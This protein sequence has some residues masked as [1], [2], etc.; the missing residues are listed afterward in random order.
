MDVVVA[1]VARFQV[2]VEARCGLTL[3]LAKSTF[4]SRVGGLPIGAREFRLAGEEVDGEFLRGFVCFGAP[5]GEDRYVVH[6]LQEVAS[7][8]ADEAQQ[9]VEVLK[10]DKQAL[11]CALRT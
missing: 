5:V 6:K 3:Q 9:T 1:A 11:W 8:I 7:R 2:E 10:A 4:Y